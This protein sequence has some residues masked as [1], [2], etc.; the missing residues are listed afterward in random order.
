MH[1]KENEPWI[2]FIH[3]EIAKTCEISFGSTFEILYNNWD[4]MTQHDEV[5]L[6]IQCTID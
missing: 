4:S 6:K 3:D 1:G 5:L 2:R